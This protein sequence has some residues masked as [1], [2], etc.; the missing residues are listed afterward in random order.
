MD[1]ERFV[2]G[3]GENMNKRKPKMKERLRSV[4]LYLLTPEEAIFAYMKVDPKRV[5]R[6]EKR[7]TKKN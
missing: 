2:V 5:I 4:S 7:A 3:K 1:I 6:A